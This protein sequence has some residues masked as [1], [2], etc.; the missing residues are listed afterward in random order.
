V[1]LS[2]AVT[3][4]VHTQYPVALAAGVQVSTAFPLPLATLNPVTAAGVGPVGRAVTTAEVA[5]WT[6]PLTDSSLN[7][8][9]PPLTSRPAVQVVPLTGNGSLVNCASPPVTLR[10]QM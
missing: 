5:P 9:T 6:N 10:V 7:S 3:L 2:P 1:K 4:R 8:Y